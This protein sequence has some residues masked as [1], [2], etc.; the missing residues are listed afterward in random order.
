MKRKDINFSMRISLMYAF[1]LFTIILSG[2][3]RKFLTIPVPINVVTGEG[4]FTN[5]NSASAVVT[6]NF[7]L[8]AVTTGPTVY[9]GTGTFG[10]LSALY[11]DE[12]QNLSAGSTINQAFY[13]DAIN[14]S[15][16]GQWPPLY[17]QLYGI[18]A[19]IE[20][21]TGTKATL[22]YKNQ[23]LGESYFSRALSYFYLVNLFGD[24]PL[25]TT[26]S[27]PVNNKLA[28]TPQAQVYQQMVADLQ[29]AQGLLST[30]YHDGYGQVTKDRARPNQLAATALL[31]RVYLYT[32][33]WT[34]AEA[35]ATTVISNT[36]Y[37]LVP[38]SQTFLA[39]SAESI[40]SLAPQQAFVNEF[41]AYN[42]NM[43][44]VITP[45]KDP[46]SYGVI[47]AMN[48]PLISAFEPGDTRFTNWVRSSTV[49]ATTTAPATTYYFPNKYKSNV[50]GVEYIVMLRLAEQYLIRAEARAEQ[51]N[52]SGAQQDLNTVRARAGLPST[53]ATT[54]AALLTAIAKERQTELFTELGNRFFDLK[55]TGAINTVMGI[56][57]PQKGGIWTSNQQIWPIPQGDIITD[58]NL[59]QAP[60]YQ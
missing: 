5:D 48:Q 13:T 50:N 29:Q 36:N 27:Y 16:A 15:E 54:Q 7:L 45:P 40:W 14:S 26:T 34:N 57:A 47:V 30:A 33:D 39:A 44:A 11:T 19:A 18:N 4:A 6:G 52:T 9:T 32:K 21:I 59:T 25:A 2:S 22:V 3:C 58:P 20:G 10:Y 37:Q 46:T 35:Q 23:W 12:T 38:P 8:M 24:V 31:A 43:P 51:N 1:C 56:V 42:N 41:T 53:T 60:G 17:G 55:R 28:R 49:T